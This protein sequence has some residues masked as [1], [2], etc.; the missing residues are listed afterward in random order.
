MRKFGLTLLLFALAV[1]AHAGTL[2][3]T[4]TLRDF[5]P[6]GGGTGHIDFENACCGMDFNIVT[7]TLGP[8]GKPIYNG[9]D[10]WSTHGQTA[11]DQWYRDVAG[12]NQ[13]L[14]YAITLDNG[15]SGNVYTY[16]TNAFFPLDGQGWMDYLSGH[17]FGFTYE[18]ASVFTYQAGQNFTFCGDDDVF[19]YI[20]NALV[21]N[22]GG[23]HG[24]TCE[25]VNLDTLGLLAGNNYNLNFFFAERHTVGSNFYMQTSI[26]NLQSTNPVPE[27]ATIAL[28]TGGLAGIG[29]L[30]RKLKK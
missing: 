5:K 24:S 20:N 12:V 1:S 4:G 14:Q 30:R 27:P 9:V 22:L 15:G 3:L 13:S 28:L 29:G 25:S 11:F 10:S 21:I 16:S 2:T 18:I 7:N 19:V 26:E 23:V 8:D 6:W 17:N